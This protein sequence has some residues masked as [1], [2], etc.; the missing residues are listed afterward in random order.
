M[1]TAVLAALLGFGVAVFAPAT[2][3]D[4]Q[5][6]SFGFHTPGYYGYGNPYGYS[7]YSY[8]YY[9]PRPFY[10]SRYHYGPRYYAP[11]GVAPRYRAPRG[12]SPRHSSRGSSCGYWSGQCGKNWGYN[13]PDYDGCLRYH[14]C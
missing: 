13:N 9:G 10:G 14:R 1:K 2:Q 7:P 11:L 6:L 3:A 5:T 8:G 4:A 12:Y